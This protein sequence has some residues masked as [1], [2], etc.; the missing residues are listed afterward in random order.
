MSSGIRMQ[1]YVGPAVPVPAPREVMEALTDVK[2]TVSDR[3][4]AFELRFRVGMDSPLHTLFLLS[5]GIPVPLLRVVVAVEVFGSTT[6]LV[7]GVMT[8][9]EVSAG[10]QSG[11][12][13][14]TVQGEDL[15]RVMDYID[16]DGLPYP[17]MPSNVR[18]MLMLAKYAFLG[19]LPLVIP[20]ILMDVPIPTNSIPSQRG[21]DLR[22]IRRL[23]DQAGYVFYLDAGPVVGT[24]VAYWGPAIKVGV[25]QPALTIGAAGME[26]HANVESVQFSVD[27]QQPSIPVV[28]IQNE[29]SRVPIPIPVPDLNP[30]SP[31][32]GIIQPIP[33]RVDFRTGTSHLSPPRAIQVGLTVASA[34]MEAVKAQGTLDVVR[35][36]RVLK[37]RQLVGLRGAG[38]AFDGLYYVKSVTHEIKRGQYKQSFT[39]TRNGLLSIVPRVVP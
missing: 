28:F 9:H 29:Q 7:D 18:V 37:A 6:V 8:R 25:P 19:V 26:A 23:A 11:Q 24:S 20:P 22:Y 15:A 17:A 3:T 2:V 14:L 4:S 10:D 16:L 32:L 35:Y 39:L 30:L 36:G 5:G 33:K 13:T 34:S 38:L 1:L 27:T 31:P 12:A 21:T